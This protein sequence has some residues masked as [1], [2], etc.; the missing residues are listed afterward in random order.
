[1]PLMRSGRPRETLARGHAMVRAA[2]LRERR[3]ELLA[4]A[5]YQ[6]G[7]QGEALAG[8]SAGSGPCSPSELGIDPS[9]DMLALEQAILHQDAAPWSLRTHKSARRSVPGKD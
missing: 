4:L 8:P 6:A 2:P 3:W 7:A 5:Q 9:P 1:M